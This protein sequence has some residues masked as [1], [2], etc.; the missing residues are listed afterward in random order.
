[1]ELT[2]SYEAAK[3]DLEF[4]DRMNRT[5]DPYTA[6]CNYC[7]KDNVRVRLNAIY[8]ICV[9]CRASGHTPWK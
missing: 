7:G 6:T 1:M 5:Q 3:A 9:E 4:I 8:Q 2:D